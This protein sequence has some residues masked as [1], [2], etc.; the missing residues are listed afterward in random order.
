[1]TALL[2]EEMPDY[3]RAYKAHFEQWSRK[4]HARKLSSR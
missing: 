1:M 2:K 3:K 4:S